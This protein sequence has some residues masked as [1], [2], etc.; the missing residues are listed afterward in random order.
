MVISASL[1][2]RGR[3]TRPA[4]LIFLKGLYR[5][6]HYIAIIAAESVRWFTR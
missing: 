5:W 1:N 4:A 6:V 2:Q 3:A